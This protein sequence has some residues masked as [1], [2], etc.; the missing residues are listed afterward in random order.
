MEITKKK[1]EKYVTIE[2]ELLEIHGS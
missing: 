1:R 2:R